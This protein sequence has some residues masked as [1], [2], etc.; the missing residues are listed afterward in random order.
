MLFAFRCLYR[1]ITSCRFFFYL[2]SL[3]FLSNNFFELFLMFLFI[4]SLLIIFYISC[5]PVFFSII[6]YIR[7]CLFLLSNFL[8][9]INYF[10][11]AAIL[12][13]PYLTQLIKHHEISFSSPDYRYKWTADDSAFKTPVRSLPVVKA[14]R[15]RLT[16]HLPLRTCLKRKVFHFEPC[17]HISSHPLFTT[18]QHSYQHTP[19]LWLTHK[20]SPTQLPPSDIHPT[21]TQLGSRL[22]DQAVTTKLYLAVGINVTCRGYGE[23]FAPRGKAIVDSFNAAVSTAWILCHTKE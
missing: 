7:S 3:L 2:L 18:P 12:Y 14:T 1:P 9:Q 16:P 23:Y 17:R 13:P 19:I 15:S 11:L 5:S 8:F 21:D 4:S 10:L 6:F 22:S 20:S